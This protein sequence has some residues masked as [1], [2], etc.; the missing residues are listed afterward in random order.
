MFGALESR[1]LSVQSLPVHA[2][3]QH[4]VRTI[5]QA[6]HCCVYSIPAAFQTHTCI[7]GGRGQQRLLVEMQALWGE[8]TSDFTRMRRNRMHVCCGLVAEW[9]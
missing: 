2:T 9:K 4:D 6:L 8:P 3:L 5:L 7:I 1:A